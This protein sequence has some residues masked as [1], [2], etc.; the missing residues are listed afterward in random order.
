MKANTGQSAALL[1]SCKTYKN[2]KRFRTATCSLCCGAKA[3]IGYLQAHSVINQMV[4]IL[5]YTHQSSLPCIQTLSICCRPNCLSCSNHRT[6]LPPQNKHVVLIS[7]YKPIQKFK[8]CIVEAAQVASECSTTWSRVV[9]LDNKPQCVIVD[10]RS[11]IP[12]SPFIS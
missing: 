6:L 12:K 4:R 1:C 9:S 5:S 2:T 3:K 7:M 11:H 10:A 8:R